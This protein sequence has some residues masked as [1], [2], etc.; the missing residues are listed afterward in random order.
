MIEDIISSEDDLPDK[1][2]GTIE[3]YLHDKKENSLGQFVL[4]FEVWNGDD[5]TINIVGE[6]RDLLA[7]LTFLK[8]VSTALQETIDEMHQDRN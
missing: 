1:I 6:S 8:E 5:V 4:F 2:S 3:D 7:R